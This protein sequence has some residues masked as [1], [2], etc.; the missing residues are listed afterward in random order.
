MIC[1]V[2]LHEKPPGSVAS[3]EARGFREWIKVWTSRTRICFIRV[4]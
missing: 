4:L 2:A 3:D 1:R